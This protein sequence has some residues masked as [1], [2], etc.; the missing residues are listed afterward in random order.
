MLPF[1]D[2]LFGTW[3]M[4]KKQWPSKYGID[5]HVAAGLAAQLLQPLLPRDEEPSVPSA[6]VAV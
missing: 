1:M 2:K 4:P 5:A 3:Y 6:Q